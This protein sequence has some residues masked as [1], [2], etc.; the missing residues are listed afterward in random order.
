MLLVN[1]TSNRAQ[2]LAGYVKGLC[3]AVATRH[4]APDVRLG[5]K[6][7]DLSFGGWKALVALEAAKAPP[8][9]LCMI[10]SSELA[11]PVIEALIPLAA[12]VVTGG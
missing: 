8:S 5:H 7:S 12:V 2:D 6:Q 1:C 11:D 4:G 9:G 3:D 10:R